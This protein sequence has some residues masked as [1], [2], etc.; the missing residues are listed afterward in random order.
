MT[1]TARVL[2]DWAH[3]LEPTAADLA[4]ADRSLLDSVAAIFVTG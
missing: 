1:S 3:E 2:A 4:L